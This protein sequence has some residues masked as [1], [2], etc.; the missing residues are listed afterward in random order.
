MAA[1][2]SVPRGRKSKR[3]AGDVIDNITTDELEVFTTKDGKSLAAVT[4][5][6]MGGMAR[7]AGLTAKKR[8][9]IA[10]KAATVRWSKG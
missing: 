6:R 5:G 7:A 4:L 8:S 9:E 2:T 3:P 1:S 10:K